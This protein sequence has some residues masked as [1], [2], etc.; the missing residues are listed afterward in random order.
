MNIENVI[1][2][3]LECFK[4]GGQTPEGWHRCAKTCMYV[5]NLCLDWVL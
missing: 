5:C 1:N 3:M 4:F 2:Y